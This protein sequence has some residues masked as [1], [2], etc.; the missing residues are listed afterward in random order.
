[1]HNFTN[2]HDRKIRASCGDHAGR[3]CAA[4]R[5][6]D[7]DLFRDAEPRKKIGRKPDTAG[8]SGDRDGF[9]DGSEAFRLQAHHAGWTTCT[10]RGE[11]ETALYHSEQG[12]AIYRPEAHGT[13]AIGFGGHDPGVCARA[14]ASLPLWLIG[15]PD[16]A[17]RSSQQSLSL[18][19]ELSHTPSMTHA[20]FHDAWLHQFRRDE[21]A[22]N[23]QAAALIARAMDQGQAMYAAMGKVFLGWASAVAG[24]AETGIG[25]MR[26]GLHEYRAT[27]A[28]S[29]VPYYKALL[30]EQLGRAGLVDEALTALQEAQ[31]AAKRALA[32][33]AFG[34]SKASASKP[35]PSSRR[36]TAV[37]PKALTHST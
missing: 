22:A 6:L 16:K 9:G 12:V 27:G 17:L 23:D 36:S 18:A 15:Y 10:Y 26:Q 14:H 4:R 32:S 20:L 30:A 28:E 29:W 24:R 2:R 11:L 3:V 13:L 1:V 31:H 33:L 7:V 19:H 34:A 35:G 8:A 21:R 5:H 25:L 37:S